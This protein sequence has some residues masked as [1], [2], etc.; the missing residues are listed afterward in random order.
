[1]AFLSARYTSMSLKSMDASLDAWIGQSYMAASLNTRLV[2][3]SRTPTAFSV[4][5]VASRRK[6]YESDKLFFDAAV[7]TF[8]TTVEAFGR[9]RYSMAVG[10]SGKATIDFGGGTRVSRFYRNDV[11]NY[12]NA[13]RDNTRFNIGQGRIL[14]DASTLDNLTAPTTGNYSHL[15]ASWNVGR[16]HY[17]P[18]IEGFEARDRSTNWLMAQVHLKSFKR[19]GKHF[20]LG[21][22]LN[23]VYTNRGLLD[24]YNATIVNAPAFTPTPAADNTFNPAF[25]ANA[26]VALGA[27]PVWIINDNLQVRGNFHVFQPMRRILLDTTTGDAYY[28]RWFSKRFAYCELAAAYT[29]RFATLSVY[30]NYQSY[31]ARNWNVGMSFGLYFLAPSLN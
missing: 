4:Q 9:L 23:A 19:L 18:G 10:R 7:P 15:M 14:L 27:V 26:F 5:A 12:V 24:N 1:M 22:E 8:I 11:G 21:G 20:S 28:G 3:P 30:G 29:F 6:Y 2:L 31:P 13:S 25:R 17:R 16:Y